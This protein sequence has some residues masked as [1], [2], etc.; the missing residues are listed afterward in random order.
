MAR[1]F[2]T[3]QADLKHKKPL[4]LVSKSC[5]KTFIVILEFYLLLRERFTRKKV[6]KVTFAR[7]GRD[8]PR[9]TAKKILF[10]GTILI[11]V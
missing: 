9:V 11:N 4:N 7:T 10:L 6:T 5:K 2:C 1:V 3:K 8:M